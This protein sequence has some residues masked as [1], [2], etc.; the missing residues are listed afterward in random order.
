ML[1]DEDDERWEGRSAREG[2]EG[3]SVI[4]PHHDREDHQARDNRNRDGQKQSDRP[5]E[6]AQ[7]SPDIGPHDPFSAAEMG[8]RILIVHPHQ[9]GS[10]TSQVSIG[11]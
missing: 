8:H 9:P 4:A 10:Y 5:H 6:R 1:R 7:E 2:R 3:L 11:K